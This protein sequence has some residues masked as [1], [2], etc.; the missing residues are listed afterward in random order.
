MLSYS[1]KSG[2]FV[3]VALDGSVIAVDRAANESAYGISG[4]LAACSTLAAAAVAY[5]AAQSFYFTATS[6]YE[7]F[8][9]DL[10][11]QHRDVVVGLDRGVERVAAR[12]EVGVANR[13]G[14]VSE[15]ERPM[16]SEVVGC[17]IIAIEVLTWVNS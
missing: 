6:I 5:V 12:L 8:L 11:P 9:P 3:G 7:S 4:V 2:L 10:L 14:D 16:P 1:R 13:D 17:D 15:C